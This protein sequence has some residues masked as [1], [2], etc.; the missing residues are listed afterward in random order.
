[1][2]FEVK[3]V[4]IPVR[5]IHNLEYLRSHGRLEIEGLKFDFINDIVGDDNNY[6]THMTVRLLKALGGIYINYELVLPVQPL[7]YDELIEAENAML[8]IHSIASLL[9]LCEWDALE[10]RGQKF[11][12]NDF[13][14]SEDYMYITHLTPRLI[15]TLGGI[16]VVKEGTGFYVQRFE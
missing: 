4:M 7:K 9:S 1:M 11:G 13:K 8:P 14:L 3:N 5:S 10:I 2:M 6:P 12:R 16:N 15:K